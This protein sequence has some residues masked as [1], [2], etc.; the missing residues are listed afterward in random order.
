[1]SDQHDEPINLN[2]SPLPIAPPI[3]R[4]NDSTLFSGCHFLTINYQEKANELAKMMHTISLHESKI[5]FTRN[6]LETL[7]KNLEQNKTIVKK[8][9]F[10][11]DY[12]SNFTHIESSTKASGMGYMAQQISIH[13]SQTTIYSNQ[14]DEG[15][16]I[17]AE[18][19]QQ[20]D[21]MELEM[22]EYRK[23]PVC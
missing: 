20:L 7:K 17:L 21:K 23:L 6:Q 16:K 18:F 8:M 12:Y 2:D 3:P 1:M 13:D 10:E 14:I 19:L 5:A 4:E 9:R 15:T 11:M 22:C